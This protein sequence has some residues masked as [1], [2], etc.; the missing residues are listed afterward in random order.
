TRRLLESLAQ[1]R[2]LVV[3]LD[4]V[5][6]ADPELLDLV[7]DVAGNARNAAVLIV[8]L[9]RP[10]LH[11]LRPSWGGGMPNASSV[12]LEPLTAAES[13]R[14]IDNLLGE[15]DL[16]TLVRDHIVGA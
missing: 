15:S 9:A 6:W 5:H 14:L 12:L 13:E 7:Q 3:V 1:K 10:E 16:P 4:D 11:D 8:C 2:P